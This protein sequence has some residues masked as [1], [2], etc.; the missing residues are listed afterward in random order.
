MLAVVAIP[1]IQGYQKSLE[2]T[3]IVQ[4]LIFTVLNHPCKPYTNQNPDKYEEWPDKSLFKFELLHST[5]MINHKQLIAI[6]FPKL[7][8]PRIFITYLIP[9]QKLLKLNNTKIKN[10]KYKIPSTYK[11]NHMYNPTRQH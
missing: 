9:I 3:T 1:T 8:N 7:L 6:N 11:S 4:Y 2:N 5:I 10:N